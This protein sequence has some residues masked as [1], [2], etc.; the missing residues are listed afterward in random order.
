MPQIK[1]VLLEL[2]LWWKED[3]RVDFKD[4]AV[5]GRIRKFMALPQII[6]L[7]GLRRV[8]KTTLMLKIIEDMIKK[9][10]DPKRILYFSFDEFRE[11]E[12]RE[13]IRQYQDIMG[14]DFGKEK[15]IMFLD[16]VQKLDNWENQLKAFYDG[17]KNI[18]VMISGSESLFIRK[19]TK[20]TLAGRIFEF[21]IEPLS[22]REFLSFR[23]ADLQPIGLYEAELKKLFGEFVLTLGFPEMAHVKDKEIIKKYV[24][25]GIVEKVIY[26]DM[27]VF[28][29]IKDISLMESLLN[30]LMED[31]GQIIEISGLSKELKISRQALSKY[32]A[33]LEASF[34]IR[35]LY[36]FSTNRR[37]IER[38]LK[39]YYP[40]LVSADLLFREDDFS[41]SKIFEWLV[42]SQLGAEFFWRDPYKNEVDV[43]IAGKKIIPIEVKYGK[44]DVKGLLAFMEK[45][46]VDAGCVI[47]Y[48][49]EEM[50][51]I[52][53]K[54]IAVMPAFKY[55]LTAD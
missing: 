48:E 40:A 19:K 28:F 54:T 51:H 6:A 13:L 23:N 4:R 29:R 20:E 35:K 50:L 46:K 39:K 24:K 45:F 41:R 1:E 26:R 8:G 27:P 21:K 32:L 17:H 2:N 31:P 5:Y 11:I 42:V 53:G 18:K 49:K 36:N 16:E 33:Y 12:I 22:F 44:I 30:L 55:F 15:G 52:G 37:K 43:I 38:K 10:F 7:T 14:I 25:E 9:G 3:F 47:S 34:L